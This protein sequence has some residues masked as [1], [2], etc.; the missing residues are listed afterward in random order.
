MILAEKIMTL[1]KQKGWSQEELAHQLEVSRQAVSKWESES[2]IPD[3]ERILKMSEIFEV[4]TDYLLK[5]EVQEQPASVREEEEYTEIV[6]SVSLEEADDFLQKRKQNA[7]KEAMAVAAYILCPE[8]LIFLAGYTELERCSLTED[9]AAG[10]GLVVLLLVVAG[11]TVVSV[12]NSSRVE[13][14]SYLKQETFRL[15]YG[16]EGIVRKRRSALEKTHR[17]YTAAGVFFCIISALPLFLVMAFT[18]NEFVMVLAVNVL[19]FLVALGVFLC[20]LGNEEWEACRILLQEGEYAPEEKESSN[21]HLRKIYWCTVTAVY[22]A[23]S[24]GGGMATGN[25]H[26]VWSVSWVIWPCAGVLFGAVRGLEHM[27]RKK[28]RNRS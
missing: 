14:Y 4:S 20:V 7:W 16:V 27:A 22:L 11:A 9:A 13:M 26:A 18:E 21:R 19:L 17:N 3:L 8:V 28:R 12:L 5:D 10:I 25:H 1:R 6:R 23:V 24:L 2:A 15:Q